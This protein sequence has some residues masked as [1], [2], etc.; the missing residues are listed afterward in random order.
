MS[1]DAPT[2]LWDP[3]RPTRPPCP[4]PCRPARQF[5]PTSLRPS[6]RFISSFER[7]GQWVAGGG[8]VPLCV[9]LPLAASRIPP[10]SS[11]ICADG[12]GPV[13][14]GSLHSPPRSL[15]YP[16]LWCALPCP[17]LLCAP[18]RSRAICCRPCLPSELPPDPSGRIPAAE[19]PLAIVSLGCHASTDPLSSRCEAQAGSF[20]AGF[21][22]AVKV[23]ATPGQQ[24]PGRCGWVGGVGFLS[25][26]LQA[27]SV[28]VS[29]LL[30]TRL[31]LGPCLLADTFYPVNMVQCCTPA[32]LLDSGDAWEL[33]RCGC[34]DSADADAPVS[35]GGTATDQ[36]L[37][38]Y[39][40]Y[41]VSPLGHV[42]PVGPA[43]CC[44]ACL[45][46]TVH[47]MDQCDD[48]S[49]CSA[50]GVCNMRRCECFQGWTGA[51]CSEV[52]RVGEW[53]GGT[54]GWALLGCGDA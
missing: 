13:T 28:T 51:D 36:L 23:F 50:H 15:P 5:T 24:Q 21:S 34:A 19:A 35:C 7:Q 1:V 42:V 53:S 43:Q 10:L 25:H 44:A 17:D 33:E 54:S 3:D 37:L 46:G 14:L 45:S 9:A 31:L 39:I 18:C 6:R 38:G 49:S 16:L 2:P 12:G 27:A 52:G 48:L 22:E 32:L 8:F 11:V 29:L 26:A 40:Y 47:P 4:L 20:V 30:K 41:R